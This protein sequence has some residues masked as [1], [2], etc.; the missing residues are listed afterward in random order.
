MNIHFG[1]AHLG[2]ES[3][4]PLKTFQ[5][6]RSLDFF[7]FAD[8]RGRLEKETG[9][10]A[11]QKLFHTFFPTR[12]M[13]IHAQP[14][15]AYGIPTN[16]AELVSD[17]VGSNQGPATNEIFLAPGTMVQL[18]LAFGL[19]VSMQLLLGLGRIALGNVN[20][21]SLPGP[22]NI[23][24][25]GQVAFIAQES[26][27]CQCRLACQAI[28]SSFHSTATARSIHYILRAQ[29]GHRRQHFGRT[30]ILAALE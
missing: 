19:G 21:F 14:P 2:F 8:S 1:T 6:T 29:H 27:M 5:T 4:T 26:S 15:L 12:L 7:G 28:L 20:G 3:T 24:Q 25:G 18:L 23:E 9:A 13:N 11:F 17:V 16:D 22:V 10:G 30:F